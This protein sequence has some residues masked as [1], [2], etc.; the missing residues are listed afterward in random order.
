MIATVRVAVATLAVLLS[1]PATAAP[2]TERELEGALRSIV[3]G[4]A[5]AG[6]RAGVLVADVASG[7]VLYARD[8]D[9]LLNPASNVKLVTS[10]A[11]LAR[12]GPGYRFATELLVDARSASGG[13]RTL[14]VRGRGDP[15]L[16]TERLYAI[17][18]ELAHLGIQRIGDVVLDDGWFDGERN[19]P[20]Y[21]QEEG[22]RS[23][24]A[25]TGALSLNWNTVA[26]F[27]SPRRP[28]R[29]EGRVELEPHRPFFE[30]V[31]RTK[32]VG[33][34]GRR[35]VKVESSLVNGRQRIVVS[36]PVPARSS[37]T[38]G[39]AQ[40]RRS[41]ALPGSH[42]REAPRAAR[43]EGHGRDPHGHGPPGAKLVHVAESD[44][45]AEIVRRLNKTSNNF[46]AEQLLKTLGAEAKGAPGSWPKGVDATAEFLAGIGIPRGAYVM[47]NG[48]GLNDTNRLSARQLVTLLRAMWSRFPLQAEYATSLPV[49]GRDGT[50]RWRMDG[51][52]ADGHLREDRHARERD[53]PL[54]LRRDRREADARL[55]DHRERLLRAPRGRGPGGGRARHRD[56]RERRDA[57]R[58]RGGRRARERALGRR[59]ARGG[60]RRSRRRGPHVLRPRAHRRPAQRRV[61]ANG[62]PR[63]TDPALRLAVAECVYLSEPDGDTAR[64]AFLE[65]VTGDPQALGR[66]WAAVGADEPA[67]VVSSLGD[68][69][70]EGEAEALARLLEIT[71]A[72]AGDAR[73]G[74]AIQE[75]VAA[76]AAS[77]PEELVGALRAAPA[78][79]QES[80][81]RVLARGLARAE[82]G[83]RPL[84]ESLR[85]MA[86]TPGDAGVFARSLAQ[87]LEAALRVDDAVRPTPRPPPRVDR[88]GGRTSGTV[89]LA[90]RDRRA[91]RQTRL[92]SL[93]PSARGARC[94]S[95]GVST[96]WRH[97]AGLAPPAENRRPREK[98][99]A[100]VN[101][102]ILVGNLGK[103]PEVRYTSGGQAVANLRIATSRS[104]TDKQSGQRKEETEWHD[105][106]VWGKQA[107]Q[108][109]EYLAKGRQVYVEGRLKTD[110]WQDKAT[111]Q[112]RY[113]VKVVAE[114]VRF[115]GGGAGAGGGRGG[116]GGGRGGHGPA[117][118]T[119]PG[120]FE[121]DG[122]QPRRRRW[123]RRGPTTFRSSRAV[124]PPFLM[125]SQRRG[126]EWRIP[127][128]RRRFRHRHRD[129]RGRPCRSGSRSV[130]CVSPD[131]VVALEPCGILRPGGSR[132]LGSR[133]RTLAHHVN[134]G[135]SHRVA[136]IR[137]ANLVAL[138]ELVA[139]ER[140]LLARELGAL[141][142]LELLGL[143]ARVQRQLAFSTFSTVPT[144]DFVSPG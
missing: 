38:G 144:I 120:G 125:E 139:R 67:P 104:W 86:E 119:P 91:R 124:H 75:V 52:A 106:E 1:A 58:A 82:E 100:M 87:R 42:A 55:R 70:A 89:D 116:G 35:H 30:V 53:E 26:V 95:A 24:L 93:E 19:G 47:K 21:D 61:P 141:V 113:K 2:P 28:P 83:E 7:D 79:L 117:R 22:D 18:G 69:A 11:A 40:D 121:D 132:L 17:A 16:V 123:R 63:E 4:S 77:A 80:A 64:R 48:S 126:P 49:A 96:R 90:A 102:V 136:E 41:T 5:L 54:R 56:R 135:R 76:V 81:V 131:G 51:T 44:T 36:G 122:G 37:G 88:P 57:R 25:P 98:A 111:G 14:Y 23:Y 99:N 29:P 137:R 108:C 71:P 130:P 105:V 142:E 103:D 12:L 20:G 59:G 60:A 115:L 94:A 129:A 73:L 3:E 140:R 32:T 128:G 127:P 43:R 34:K 27:T 6:A 78:P 68:L 13:A 134:L 97:A 107:E 66:L 118:A 46:V 92:L 8:A 133:R 65:T 109:G 110:K 101:R 31:N 143:G 10:A 62:A 9:V 39:V 45:L 74:A 33:P 138:R 114:T 84:R 15:T 85:E 112:E 50:I 72:A